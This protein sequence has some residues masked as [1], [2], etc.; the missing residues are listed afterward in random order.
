MRR[1]RCMCEW[2]REAKGGMWMTG[3]GV[4]DTRCCVSEVAAECPNSSRLVDVKV[5]CVFRA[6]NGNSERIHGRENRTWLETR[7]RTS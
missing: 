1:Y 7:T 6:R 4:Q 2:N 5:I 3:N